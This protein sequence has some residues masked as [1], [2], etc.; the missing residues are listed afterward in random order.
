MIEI[1]AP[2]LPENKP[3][4]LMGVGS[5]E[6]ILNGVAQGIDMFD[7]VLP[8]RVARNGALFTAKGRLNIRNS[9]W[10]ETLHRLILPVIA[11]PAA[12]FPRLICTI[13][14]GRK[15]CWLIPWRLFIIS[16]LCTILWPGSGNRLLRVSSRLQED[17][18]A[19]YQTTDETVRL[20]QKQK[21]LEKWERS[22]ASRT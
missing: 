15:S 12:I 21:W 4:Y 3:R 16:L 2:F 14:S 9:M 7:S 6:D 5:P 19:G 10:K 1:T 8:T 20:A 11:I 18:L 22:E 13:F 17:F